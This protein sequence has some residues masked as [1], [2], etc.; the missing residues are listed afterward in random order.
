MYH[1]RLQQHGVLLVC[2]P[3]CKLCNSLCII[4]TVCSNMGCCLCVQ[5]TVQAALAL[6]AADAVAAAYRADPTG[7]EAIRYSGFA[8]VALTI[9]VFEILIAGTLGTLL[10]RFSAPLLLEKV[11]CP[12]AGPSHCYSICFVHHELVQGQHCCMQIPRALDAVLPEQ[13]LT[14]IYGCKLVVAVHTTSSE[15]RRPSLHRLYSGCIVLACLL[16]SLV[17]SPYLAMSV[18]SA[19]MVFLCLASLKQMH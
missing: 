3:Q 17:C 5:A 14:T 7:D 18:K 12:L 15:A 10:I 16:L 1:H 4:T 11:Q 8:T 19:L 2:R 6:S 9:A 13:H